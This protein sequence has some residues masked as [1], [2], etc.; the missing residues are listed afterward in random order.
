MKNVGGHEFGKQYCNASNEMDFMIPIGSIFDYEK[1]LEVES[2]FECCDVYFE[3]L[4]QEILN[5]NGNIHT[6]IL[7][8]RDVRKY[9]LRNGC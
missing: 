2:S 5:I 9:H 6:P 8:T 7:L 1:Y 3:N 4:V